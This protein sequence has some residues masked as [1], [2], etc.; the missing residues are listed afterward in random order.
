MR[1]LVFAPLL[2]VSLAATVQA[3]TA[4][5]ETRAA[6]IAAEQQEKAKDLKPYAPN[7]AE[8]WV[9]ELDQT[10]FSGQLR[11]HPFFESA[12]RG[13]G[14]TLGAGYLA[15]VGDYNW[16]DVRGSVTPSG[17]IRAEGEFRAPR[18][19]DRRGS[20]SVIGGW[21]KAT[22]VGY[23]GL[24]T[25]NTSKDDRALYSFTQPYV[26]GILDVRPWRH[27]LVISGGLDY[28][29]WNPGP[30]QGS[31]PSIEEV[32]TPETAP[33]L[34]ATP[35]YVHGFGTLAADSRPAPGYARR[36]GYYAASLH[37]YADSDSLYSFQRV[38]YEAIQ[39]VPLG[40]DRWVL[41]LRGK[42]E[43][44]YTGGGHTVPYFMMPSLGGG[45]DMR[46]FSSWRFRDLHS[47]LLQAEWRV[48]VNAFFDT[49]IFYDTGKVTS[50][51]SELDFTELK[52]DYGIGF[53]LHGPLAT[54]IRIELAN[55]N[56]GFH[57][58]FSSSAVF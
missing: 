35:T 33:G 31:S 47:L 29:E 34:G 23:Y 52:S 41:S 16:V 20:L 43:T 37:G 6:R 17:Y 30:A 8:L 1:R 48:L 53:R 50:R 7:K 26:S 36:G 21:R 38:D 3:Q 57:L 24:G 10:F 42:V 28:A 19:F 9:K 49:A 56:E 15:H 40:R 22:E 25:A 32:Y 27:W 2:F 39:H 55:S 5:Q 18:L 13:G 4:P 12:Y 44:T 11:W 51:R 58:I 54:P 46:G 14:F 45:S